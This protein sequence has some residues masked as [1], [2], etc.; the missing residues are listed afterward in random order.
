M[1]EL[2]YMMDVRWVS[3]RL[4]AFMLVF[5]EDALRLICQYSL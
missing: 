2:C 3:D 4:V 1:K 5:E